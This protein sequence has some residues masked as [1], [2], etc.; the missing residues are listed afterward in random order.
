M[1]WNDLVGKLAG[2]HAGDALSF[3]TNIMCNGCIAKVKPILDDAVGI[4]SWKVDLDSPDRVLSVVS[5]GMTQDEIMALVRNAGFTIE[6][7]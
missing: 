2:R 5:D 4:A 1:K 6:P 7:C 3:R